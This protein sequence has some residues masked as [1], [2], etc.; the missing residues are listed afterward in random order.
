MFRTHVLRATL[1][2]LVGT[3]IALVSLFPIS[4][5]AMVLPQSQSIGSCNEQMNYPHYS[6]G[7]GGAVAKATFQCG[8]S[9]VISYTLNLYVCYEVPPPDVNFLNANCE[10]NAQTSGAF[11]ATPGQQYTQVVPPLGQ[12]GAHGCGYWAATDNWTIDFKAA[13][14]QTDFGINPTYFCA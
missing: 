3:I 4:A 7:A 13:F 6:S 10:N 12:A 14:G 1:T 5:S 11:R 9:H 8:T 2:S